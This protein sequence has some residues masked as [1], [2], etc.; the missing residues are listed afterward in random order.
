MQARQEIDDLLH[1]ND[2]GLALDVL[3]LLT[4][5]AGPLAV[6]DLAA[7]TITAPQTAAL[8]RRIRRLLTT[9]AAR[10]FQTVTG[11][12]GAERYQF[13][14]ESL[15]AYAQADDDLNHADFRRRIHQW[16]E[17]WKAIGWPTPA[18]GNEGTPQYLLDAYPATLTRIPGGWH[19]DQ[20]HWLGRGSD[21]S[22]G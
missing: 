17:K 11:S 3:A 13:A 16:A 15:L 5:A 10:S 18:D 12:A 8:G 6:R 4:A 2:D 14:H 20:R 1:R 19:T 21:P 9:S 7:M 22:T